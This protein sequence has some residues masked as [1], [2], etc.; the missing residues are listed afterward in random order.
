MRDADTVLGI[1]HARGAAGLPLEDIYR[2]L[3]NP[4]LYLRAYDRIRQNNGAMTPG[5]SKETVDGM[6]LEKIAGIT[7]ALRFERYQ[8]TPARRV[9]IPKKD[10]K[11]RP[12]GMPTWSD[13]LLQEVMRSILE[14]YYEPQFSPASH[15]FRPERGCHTALQEIS[16]IWSGTKWFIEGDISKCFDMLDHTVLMDI[17]REKLH[18]GRFLRLLETMLKAGYLEDWKWNATYSGTPQGGVISPI[19]SNIYLDRLDRYVTETLIPEYNRGEQRARNLVYCRLEDHARRAKKNGHPELYRELDAQKRRLPYRDPNDPDYRRLRYVRY[20]D[21]FLL[22][23]AGPRAD[24]ERIKQQLKSYLM[25]ELKL[26]LSTSKTLI[27]HATTERARFLG[28]E[29]GVFLSDTK[30]AN[31]QRSINGRIQLRVPKDVIADKIAKYSARGKAVHRP[32]LL[33]ASE[34][35]II[36]QYQAVYRGVI[37]YYIMAHNVNALNYLHQVMRISLAK[38]LASKLKV[39]A[40]VVTAKYHTTVIT[41]YGT[42]KCLRTEIAREGKPSLVATFGGI[43]LRRRKAVK[44]LIDSSVLPPT[45]KTTDIVKRLLATKCETCG[46]TGDCEVHHI[47]KMADLHKDGRREKPMWMQHMIRIKRKTLVVCR[48]CHEDIHQGRALKHEVGLESRV[49]RK[50]QARFGGGPMEKDRQRYLASGL[51]NEIGEDAR[52]RR[53]DNRLVQGGQQ[54]AQLDADEEQDQGHGA[55]DAGT[56]TRERRAGDRC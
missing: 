12:L 20:A 53:A 14:A 5:A 43:P 28:Y 10:G 35:S 30:I 48:S 31:H 27:T 49:P 21:D 46:A 47:R 17:L 39:S 2:Q 15:G 9:Y 8:W 54:L 3:F 55:G 50:W 11:Q 25:S 33:N 40:S 37:Q 1:I 6:S 44:S 29:V 13:K 56:A 7:E 32:E 16:S 22:G 52:H 42:M 4:R 23:F 41:P 51:P 38:T 26:D 36:E 45:W 18:D 19:L 34:F 24:A